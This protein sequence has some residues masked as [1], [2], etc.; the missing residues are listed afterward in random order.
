MATIQS[1]LRILNTFTFEVG[2]I[3][4]PSEG[5][6][7]SLLLRFTC[8][9]PWNLCTFC[10]GSPYGRKKFR[11]RPIH[12]I[13]ADI[14]NVKRIV[15]CIKELSTRLGYE[16]IFYDELL[17]IIVQNVDEAHL[18]NILLVFNWLKRGCRSVFIQDADSMIMRSNDLIEA[19]RYLKSS[20]PQIERITTY[21]RAKSI[22]KKS[23][24]E[25]KEIYDAGL[26]RLHVGLE[27]GD[28]VVL[29]RVKKGIS[30][31]EHIASGI[32]AKEAGFEV[33]YYIMP[34]LGG[35]ERS[36]EHAKNT[37]YV[38]N[39]INPDFVRSRP[40]IP[41]LGT[42]LYREYEQ[43]SFKLLSPHELLE[44]IRLMIENLDFSGRLCFDHMR[45]PCY[46]ASQGY[47]PLFS[48]DY[49]GYK[50]PDQKQELI[51]IIDKGLKIPESQ[52]LS[53][54]EIIDYEKKIYHI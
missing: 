2:P 49:E 38:I 31:K 22:L 26:K 43:G 33:S 44:E 24:I 17:E 34:G 7:Y 40:L 30:S 6:S 11:Y 42:P 51:K 21:A 50:F 18:E 8:N 35:R 15:E 48:L 19:L 4:P 25:L 45:N 13:K 36:M 53:T 46:F 14:D 20:F 3:R 1:I 28:D 9:C 47:V 37:A 23:S 29:K 39:E 5:G 54:K 52:F 12:E 10:Y 16:G 27:S 32:K 41:R